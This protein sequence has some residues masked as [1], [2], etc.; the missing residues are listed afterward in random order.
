MKLGMQ[1]VSI[2]IA[3]G[4]EGVESFFGCPV[5]PHKQRVFNPE[6]PSTCERLCIVR[7]LPSANIRTGPYVTAVGATTTLSGAITKD[8]ERAATH[9]LSGGGFS[10]NFARPSYQQDAVETYFRSPRAPTY[11]FYSG[12]AYGNGQYNRSGR[13]CKCNVSGLSLTLSNLTS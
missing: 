10:N 3:S 13:G 9:I 7:S 1:G 12:S 11:P 5:G 6:F 4:D 2:V 8:R